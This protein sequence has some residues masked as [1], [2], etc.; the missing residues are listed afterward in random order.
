MC[1]VLY[2]ING[3]FFPFPIFSWQYRAKEHPIY[4]NY[5][6]LIWWHQVAF[7]FMCSYLFMRLYIAGCMNLMVYNT[8]QTDH[9][10][11]RTL[12][13]I[14][15]DV[16]LSGMHIAPA[17]CGLC[18]YQSVCALPPQDHKVPMT[19]GEVYWCECRCQKKCYAFRVETNAWR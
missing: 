1:A 9:R 4:T 11:H 7:I 19:W 5:Y 6:F 15:H 2:W 17:T 18:P 14:I 10:L 13:T 8:Q 3:P 12:D 16:V